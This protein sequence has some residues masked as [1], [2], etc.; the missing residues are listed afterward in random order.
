MAHSTEAGPMLVGSCNDCL[1]HGLFVILPKQYHSHPCAFFSV[2]NLHHT[3]SFVKMLITV[4]LLLHAILAVQTSLLMRSGDVERNPGPGRYPGER[5]FA[6]LL[7]TYNN[8]II[9]NTFPHIRSGL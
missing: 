4:V 5:A 8:I 6:V 3:T 9:C 7:R 2:G 1:L